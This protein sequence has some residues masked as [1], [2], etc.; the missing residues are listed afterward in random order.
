M[1]KAEQKI[2]DWL[3]LCLI[4]L[5]PIPGIFIRK[6]VRCQMRSQSFWRI[7]ICELHPVWSH[8]QAPT[9]KPPLCPIPPAKQSKH[10]NARP[11][12]PTADVRFDNS[13]QC[14]IH[15]DN[16]G[17]CSFCPKRISSWKCHKSAIFL[18]LNVN[19]NCFVKYHHK[20]SYWSY[21]TKKQLQFIAF[22]WFVSSDFTLSNK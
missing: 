15:T 16:Q 21:I 5:Y 7:F 12:Q 13:A 6:I 10:C 19:Q 8:H 1:D 22:L 17:R 9:C 11:S 14:T 18:G 3:A 20:G 4:S 2:T